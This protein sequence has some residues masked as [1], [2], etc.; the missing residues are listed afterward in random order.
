MIEDTTKHPTGELPPTPEP[1]KF[2][3][4]VIAPPVP[5]PTNE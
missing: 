3:E 5:A 2:P 4:P 1:P